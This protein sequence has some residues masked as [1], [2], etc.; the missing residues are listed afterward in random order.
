MKRVIKVGDR[1]LGLVDEQSDALVFDGSTEAKSDLRTAATALRMNHLIAHNNLGD[2]NFRTVQL[3]PRGSL[4][5]ARAPIAD[6]M[7]A[8][9][10][11]N[12]LALDPEPLAD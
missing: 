10:D 4:R 11:D 8:L 7:S 6:T 2:D 9:H 3:T 5:M 1:Y 12:R